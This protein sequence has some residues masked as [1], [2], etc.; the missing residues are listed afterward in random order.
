MWTP[1][2]RHNPTTQ[3][4]DGLFLKKQIVISKKNESIVAC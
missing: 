4:D 1:N 3:L 2:L